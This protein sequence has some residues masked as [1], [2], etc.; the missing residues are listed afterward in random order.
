[1]LMLLVKSVIN[2]VTVFAQNFPH[3]PQVSLQTHAPLVN[4]TV[5]DTLFHAV[6]NV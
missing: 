5:N 6:P 4:C 2:V 1:M 3:Y